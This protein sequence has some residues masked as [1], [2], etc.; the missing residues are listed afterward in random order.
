MKK[1]LCRDCKAEIQ[2]KTKYL[3]V[4]ATASEGIHR[5]SKRKTVFK[6]CKKCGIAR[7]KKEQH[8]RAI[9]RIGRVITPKSQKHKEWLQD[10]G[11]I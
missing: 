3:I 9:D 8:E 6:L 10:T 11:V 2:N 1:E 7:F 5:N 4:I